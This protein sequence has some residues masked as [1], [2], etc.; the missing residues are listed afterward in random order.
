MKSHR[1]KT[2][3]ESLTAFMLLSNSNIDANQ[4]ISMLSAATSH[5]SN[6]E[7]ATTNEELINSVK[8]NPIASV[9]RQCDAN[10]DSSSATLLENYTTFPRHRWNRNHR[11]PQQ[12]AELKKVS[13][14]KTCG[15]WGH[16]HS[17][18]HPNGTLKYGAKSYR[19]PPANHIKESRN[20]PSRCVPQK[21]SMT[22][23]IVNMTDDS[24][25]SP[26]HFIGPLLDEGAPCSGLGIHELKMLSP[27][28]R[29]TWHEQL[30]PLPA[31]IAD[32]SHWQ[33]GSDSHSNDSLRMLG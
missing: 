16:W 10:K 31:E 9:L 4:R 23:N 14:C 12:I 28:L 18:H 22:F 24:K 15:K 26:S 21:K 2:L 7:S 11:T 25:L 3:P 33:Y 5:S 19:T 6:S 32:R 8:Y 29:T 30:D 1:S 17:Y 20:K 13:R 27:Y